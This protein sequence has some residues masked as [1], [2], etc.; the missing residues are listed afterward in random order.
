MA[1]PAKRPALGRELLGLAPL[2]E[3]ALARVPLADHRNLGGTC[4]TLRRLVFGDEFARMRKTLGATEYGLI[5]VGSSMYFDE[6][7]NIGT[8]AALVCPTHDLRKLGFKK[9]WLER[10]LYL[11]E[12]TTA[13]S[14]DD[15]IV[16][17]GDTHNDSLDIMIYD[18]RT[19][20]WAQDPPDVQDPHLPAELPEIM[21]GQCTAF[22][23]NVLVVAAGAHPTDGT[24][25]WDE[26]SQI[27]ER[28]PSM[29]SAAAHSGYCVIGS[30]LF[31]VGGYCE[32]FTN[33]DTYKPSPGTVSCTHTTRL[34]IY[35]NT[36]RSWSLGPPLTAL[37]ERGERVLTAVTH[38]RCVYVIAQKEISPMLPLATSVPTHCYVYDPR[39]EV[40]SELGALPVGAAHMSLAACVHDGRLV[41]GGK[42][43]PDLQ[44]TT[45]LYEL[46]EKSG[47]WRRK[48][49]L[50]DNVELWPR[51]GVA[52][53]VS[54][55]LRLRS[56]S[57]DPCGRY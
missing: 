26:Q 13:Y 38:N 28:L 14:S 32:D 1:A 7:E 17:C 54:F 56:R 3:V 9:S 15:R 25:S 24:F 19:H 30:R 57:I 39:A 45:F 44:E 40:W 55:P 27:W 48:S 52:S 23:D 6:D 46:N 47:T 12:F 4:R 43:G 11:W 33:S 53:L 49:M 50:V 36:T 18:T 21:Y 16:I 51:L 2:L 41:V 42:E 8:D 22:I 34:Q 31:V 5:V 37:K 35:D 29:P 20:W 10:S